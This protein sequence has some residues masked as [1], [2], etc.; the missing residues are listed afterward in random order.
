MQ[1]IGLTTG[2]IGGRWYCEFHWWACVKHMIVRLCTANVLPASE[3]VN[4]ERWD[5]LSTG[6]CRAAGL[7][8]GAGEIRRSQCSRGEGRIPGQWSPATSKVSVYHLHLLRDWVLSVSL[9]IALFLPNG[10]KH[11]WL[12]MKLDENQLE[13]ESF[14]VYYYWNHEVVSFLLFFKPVIVAVK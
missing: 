1:I 9:F 13:F 11:G 8:R 2:C 14:L 7:V 6:D 4:F 12:R 10:T 5:I 3:G